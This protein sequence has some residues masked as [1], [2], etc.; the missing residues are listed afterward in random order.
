MNTYL[1]VALLAF[2]YVNMCDAPSF[3]EGTISAN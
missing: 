1:C 2:Q 3:F